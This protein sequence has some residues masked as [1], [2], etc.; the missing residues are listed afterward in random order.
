MISHKASDNP[1]HLR[2]GGVFLK[3]FDFETLR[4][5]RGP[6]TS[7]LGYKHTDQ[8]ISKMKKYYENKDNHP[9]LGRACTPAPKV[10]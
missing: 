9:T 2:W 10:R 3:R 8:A 5:P 7:L 6:A 4:A 1:P